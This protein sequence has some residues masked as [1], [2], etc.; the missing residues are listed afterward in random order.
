M[1]GLVPHPE[2]APILQQHCVALASD[3][4]DPEPEVIELAERLEDAM[5]LPFVLFC[6]GQGKYLGGWSGAL[7]PVTFRSLLSQVIPQPA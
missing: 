5:M 4:D 3:C 1:Q 7:S 2:F 6:D